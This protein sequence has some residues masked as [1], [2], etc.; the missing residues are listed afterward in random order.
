[1]DTVVLLVVRVVDILAHLFGNDHALGFLKVLGPQSH[2][3]ELDFDRV[4]HFVGDEVNLVGFHHLKEFLLEVL[5]LVLGLVVFGRSRHRHPHLTLVY[6]LVRV[7]NE[8]LFK[9]FLEEQFLRMSQFHYIVRLLVVK[10][11]TGHFHHLLLLRM[12]NAGSA[13]WTVLNWI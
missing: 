12:R 5:D 3:L 1:M 2:G 7:E 4:N 10:H 8:L 11:K 6:V 9:G 13:G